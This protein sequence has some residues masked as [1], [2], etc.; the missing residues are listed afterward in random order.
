VLNPMLGETMALEQGQSR[1]TLGHYTI[2]AQEEMQFSFR[3][4]DTF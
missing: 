1:M 2:G 4:V 3:G